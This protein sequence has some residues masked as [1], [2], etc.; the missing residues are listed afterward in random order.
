MKMKIIF[1]NKNISKFKNKKN[2]KKNKMKWN[3]LKNLIILRNRIPMTHYFYPTF[4]INK[5]L[6]H[7][8]DS[9]TTTSFIGYD[10]IF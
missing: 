6:L 9:N 10:F 5:H 8:S 4:L 7:L 3:E 1:K 2:K